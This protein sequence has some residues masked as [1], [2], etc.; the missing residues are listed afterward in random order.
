MRIPLHLV[1]IVLGS[2]HV[3]SGDTPPADT[4]AAPSASAGG[5]VE[6]AVQLVD[7]LGIKELM[8]SRF[9]SSLSAVLAQLKQQGDE[10]LMKEITDITKAFYEENYKWESMSRT[11]ASAYANA[12]TDDEMKAAISFYQTDAG[13][14]LAGKS[15]AINAEAEKL[16]QEKMKPKLLEMQRAMLMAV[17]KRQMEKNNGKP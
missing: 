12:M 17:Q 15:E 16:T 7:V 11:Y 14:K 2:I 5:T 6:V 13:K 3:C 9:D 10:K 8:K 1:L 4:K